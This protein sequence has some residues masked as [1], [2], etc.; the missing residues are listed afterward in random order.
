[1]NAPLNQVH[2]PGL[3][4]QINKAV[5]RRTPRIRILFL[6]I[7]STP[8]KGSECILRILCLTSLSRSNSVLIW[9]FPATSDF[10]L[11]DYLSLWSAA[12]L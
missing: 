8:S 11:L 5:S 9:E 4:R 3:S 2:I 7:Q 12:L 1:M 6:S 10:R